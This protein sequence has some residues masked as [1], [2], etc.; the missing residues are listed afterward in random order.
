MYILTLKDLM[1]TTFKCL[2][3]KRF[4]I[5]TFTKNINDC[6]YRFLKNVVCM[7]SFNVNASGTISLVCPIVLRKY[8]F[9][10]Q[11]VLNYHLAVD[12]VA[13]MDAKIFASCGNWGRKV[14]RS[15]LNKTFNKLNA[16]S[17]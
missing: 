9:N 16:V 14:K 8:D 10:S 7:K 3:K 2:K 1:Q 13:K 5:F 4:S 17:T 15:C 11:R 6:I 12:D